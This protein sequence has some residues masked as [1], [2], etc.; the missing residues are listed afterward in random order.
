MGTHAESGTI[1]GVTKS[2]VNF[3]RLG[4]MEFSTHFSNKPTRRCKLGFAPDADR[5]SPSVF[6]AV[7]TRKRRI[8]DAGRGRN[9]LARASAVGTPVLP[10]RFRL[11]PFAAVGDGLVPALTAASGDT[12]PQRDLSPGSLPVAGSRRDTGGLAALP[13]SPTPPFTH[14]LSPALRSRTCA[15][16]AFARW[17]G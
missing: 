11:R 15:P 17:N 2:S 16:T 14:G 13:P 6:T 7:R 1:A 4:R 3:R 8:Q 10:L 5:H 9:F 12:S